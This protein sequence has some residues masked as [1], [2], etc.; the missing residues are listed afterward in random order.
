MNDPGALPAWTS[1]TAPCANSPSRFFFLF[2]LAF[3]FTARTAGAAEPGEPIRLAYVEGDV[4]G[5]SSIL[6]PDGKSTI[7]FLEYRQHRRGEIL[8][9]SRIAHFEDGS[10]DEDRI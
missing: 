10:S 8:E 3:A 4:A 1:A 9:I 7:G 2:L 5:M 6:S